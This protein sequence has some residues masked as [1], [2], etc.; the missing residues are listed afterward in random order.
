MTT[1]PALPFLRRHYT[2]RTAKLLDMQRRQGSPWRRR[3]FHL[4]YPTPDTIQL[5]EPLLD[6]PSH[7]A[8]QHWSH[9]GLAWG[10]D[11][12]ALSLMAVTGWSSRL[13]LTEWLIAHDR[14]LGS[15]DSGS[16][17]RLWQRLTERIVNYAEPLVNE[18]RET[19]DAGHHFQVVSV[20]L[21]WTGLE[22]MHEMGIATTISEYERL[23]ARHNAEAQPV[24]T[25]MVILTAHY[26]RRHGFWTQVCPRRAWP[27]APDILA[28]DPVSER[29]LYVEVEAPQSTGTSKELRLRRKWEMQVELQGFACLV[30]LTPRQRSQRVR[31]AADVSPDG[32]A[33]D[34]RSL[35]HEPETLWTTTWG[36]F[37]RY[38]PYAG[39]RTDQTRAIQGGHKKEGQTQTQNAPSTPGQQAPEKRYPESSTW[40][41]GPVTAATPPAWQGAKP[42]PT[43][44]AQPPGHS[45]P[46]LTPEQSRPITAATPP[47][48]QGAKPSP[49]ESVQPPGH[50]EPAVT[51]EQSRPDTVAT[52]PSWPRSTFDPSSW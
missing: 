12:R 11:L 34:L 14:S 5:P 1:P 20:S 40:E 49:T 42:S 15:A 25:A 21:S 39:R 24:H 48:W 35:S 8:A 6:R 51:P 37:S 7:Y 43:E 41:R 17:K 32:M 16:I 33:T 13:S 2:Q 44:S 46:A 23:V 22:F 45:E 36:S 29:T 30:A 19:I 50:S 9:A 52:P 38:N 27:L 4:R 31:S 28:I 3:Y 26:L 18:Y 47:S 10:R